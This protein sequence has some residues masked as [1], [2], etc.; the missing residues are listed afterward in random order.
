MGRALGEFE[1]M[2]LYALLHL[3]DDAYGVS[4]RRTIESRAKRDVSPGA[5]YTTLERLENRSLVCSRVARV[6]DERGTRERKYFELRPEGVLE[7]KRSRDALAGMA[8]GLGPTLAALAE[9]A[10][11]QVGA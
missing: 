6:T 10:A 4:I 7:L 8:R 11:G 3:G 2:V 5:V 9:Q 1:Q